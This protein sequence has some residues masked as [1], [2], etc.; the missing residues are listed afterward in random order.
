MAGFMHLKEDNYSR[1][2]ISKVVTEEYASDLNH[3]Y[4]E[5]VSESCLEATGFWSV[6][7]HCNI[8][9]DIS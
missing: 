1:G 4:D 5:E 6:L 3:L 7:L 2:L 8:P 9:Y